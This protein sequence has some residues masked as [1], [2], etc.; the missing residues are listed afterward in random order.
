MFGPYSNLP[1]PPEGLEPRALF[2]DPSSG[3]SGGE[4]G[5]SNS[6]SVVAFRAR[7]G[8]MLCRLSQFQFLFLQ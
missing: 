6:Y 1:P 5:H 7:A 4:I 2:L 3:P 8:I